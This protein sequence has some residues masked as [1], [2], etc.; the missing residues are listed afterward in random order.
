VGGPLHFTDRQLPACNAWGEGTFSAAVD[1]VAALG[2]L[3]DQLTGWIDSEGLINEKQPQ[4][5]QA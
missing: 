5:K 1:G 3:V 4:E 2:N